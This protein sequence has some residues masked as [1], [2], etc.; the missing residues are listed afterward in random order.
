MTAIP[1]RK[2]KTGTQKEG[3]VETEAQIGMLCLQVKWHHG[4]STCMGQHLPESLPKNQPCQHPNFQS[5]ASR[6]R[7]YISVALSKTVCG[8]YIWQS[9]VSNTIMNTRNC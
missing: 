9:Q 7:S 2:E 6:L 8:S 5:L 4:L 1:V 3:H